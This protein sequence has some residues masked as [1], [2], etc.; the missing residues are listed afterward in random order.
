MSQLSLIQRE[1]RP[2][3]AQVQRQAIRQARLGDL[4][5]G[6]PVAFYRLKRCILRLSGDCP[7]RPVR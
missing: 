7:K 4:G 3:F 6:A 2:V 5:A 1:D